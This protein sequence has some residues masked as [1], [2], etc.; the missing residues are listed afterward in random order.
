[1]IEIPNYEI[2][3]MTGRGGV[4]E[5]YKATHKLLDR[6]VAVKVISHAKSGDVADKRFLKEA[7][8]VAGLRHSN[9]VSIYDVGILENKYYIIMEFLEGGDLKQKLEEGLSIDESIGIL[10]QVASALAHA[11]DKGFIHRDIKSQNIMFRSDGTA[12]LTDFGI[13]KDLTVDSGYTM[14]GTSVGTPHYMSPEQAQ[15]SS[16]IDW[17]TDLYSLGVTFYEMLTG[18]V[19]YTADSAVAVALKHIKDPVPKLPGHLSRY[20]SIIERLMAKRPEKRFQSAHELLEALEN[21]PSADKAEPLVDT[22]ELTDRTAL[23]PPR[24]PVK[25]G[26]LYMAAVLTVLAVF[27]VG[28]LF[29]SPFE[30]IRQKIGPFLSQAVFRTEDGGSQESRQKET[31]T[32]EAGKSGTNA[33]ASEKAEAKKAPPASPS[34]PT[35]RAT[36]PLERENPAPG[37]D[38]EKKRSAREK[39]AQ[40]TDDVERLYQSARALLEKG[41]CTAALELARQALSRAPDHRELKRLALLCRA[42]IS[43]KEKRFTV[44]ADDNALAYYRQVLEMD[45]DNPEARKGIESIAAWFENQARSAYQNEDYERALNNIS[46]YREIKPSDN[47][48]E[49][50][51][52]MI[53]GNLQYAAGRYLSPQGDNAAHYFR[54]VL[55]KAPQKEEIARR[56]AKA[57]VLGAISEID[58]KASIQNQIP[59]F[60][61]AF[62]A[63]KAGIDDHGDE[64]MTDVRRAMAERVKTML[65]A[66][67]A[68]PGAVPD[69]FI[70]LVTGYFPE[71]GDNLQERYED[72]VAR[73]DGARGLGNQ[74]DFYLEALRL[75]PSRD[76]ARE[77]IKTV[78]RQMVGQGDAQA[79][80]VLKEAMKAAPDAG[81]FKTMLDSIQSVRDAKAELF[82]RLYQ[83][84]GLASFSEKMPAY[85]IFLDDLESAVAKYGRQ[86]MADPLETAKAQLKNEVREQKTQGRKLPEEFVQLTVQHFPELEDFISDAQYEILIKR[87]E[88]AKSVAEKADAYIAAL[89]LNP[90]RPEASEAIRA[91]ILGAEENGEREHAISMLERAVA[92]APSNGLIVELEEEIGRHVEIYPTAGGCDEKNR[93]TEAPVTMDTLNFCLEYRNMAPDSIVHISIVKDGGQSMDMPLLLQS[94]SGRQAISFSAPVEGFTVGTYSIAVKQKQRVLSSSQIQ[95]IPKRR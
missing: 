35:G 70:S 53:R 30:Q 63:L 76:L 24:L 15:G 71:F 3:Q 56:L 61:K 78:A 87:A 1:M 38:T 82:T 83:I 47:D 26:F 22:L 21:L 31:G 92:A 84:K 75:N 43:F 9:I 18:A 50:M 85:R 14:D 45:P 69:E 11:H 4:A 37:P 2:G 49:L 74:A 66:G 34:K 46:K 25:R 27:A 57:R 62:K 20:Q 41:N 7:R 80:V 40:K 13:V 68:R 79:V 44:P 67:I 89:A 52:W 19:P 16:A 39:A 60:Q 77:K 5:V 28:I 6:T 64:S 12:V 42:R 88:Q 93:I 65:D 73:G 58:T 36:V 95:F 48:A 55:N 32:T 81:E 91:L 33:S 29:F 23:R 10:K 72:L 90:N 51:E 94:N 17:R 54:Q 59:Q 86:K 8:V